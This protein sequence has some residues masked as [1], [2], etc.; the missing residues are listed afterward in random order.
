MYKY[1]N[2]K[3]HMFNFHKQ[4]EMFDIYFILAF[5][6]ECRLQKGLSR[7]M[8]SPGDVTISGER[9]LEGGKS[10]IN[11]IE[12]SPTSSSCD[13]ETKQ[14]TKRQGQLQRQ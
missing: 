2:T 3:I 6:R 13:E 7:G 14:K 1:K 10:N 8:D 11:V 5:P 9:S 4:I 12:T